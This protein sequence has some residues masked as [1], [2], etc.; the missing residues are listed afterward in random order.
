MM[1]CFGLLITC[2]FAAKRGQLLDLSALAVAVGHG[3]C[4]LK[5]VHITAAAQSAAADALQELGAS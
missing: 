2:L 3:L 5:S 4:I 1:H